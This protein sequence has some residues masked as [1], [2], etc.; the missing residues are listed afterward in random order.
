MQKEILKQRH[1]AKFNPICKSFVRENF[2]LIELL[3]VIAIIAILAAMLLPALS[4]AKAMAQRSN[5]AGNV[6]Q[7]I[8]SSIIYDTDYESALVADS[9]FKYANIYTNSSIQTLYTDYLGGT[10]NGETTIS[11]AIRRKPKPNLVCPSIIPRTDYLRCTY[12]PYAGCAKNLKMT[13][14]QMF[15]KV[16]KRTNPAVYINGKNLALWGDR[17]LKGSADTNSGGI[18]ETNHRKSSGY[19]VGG[20]VGHFD[21]SVQWY[22]FS[23]SSTGDETFVGNGVLGTDLTVPASA[24]YPYLIAADAGMV[25]STSTMVIGRNGSVLATAF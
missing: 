21:G 23:A 20:N 18:T 25:S 1:G 7:L 5:C 13:Y 22:D 24:T 9:G 19:P 10:L 11:L 15:N 14:E 3:V 17:C 12:A 2:T 8:M 16:K 4:Q 6:R